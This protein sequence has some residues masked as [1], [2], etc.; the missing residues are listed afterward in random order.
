MER[1][2]SSG[3]TF[4]AAPIKAGAP[5]GEFW[6]QITLPNG[7]QIGIGQFENSFANS[8]EAER[9]INDHIDDPEYQ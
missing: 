7:K 6:V 5:F 2:N 8:G 9:W 4:K 1:V 3:A